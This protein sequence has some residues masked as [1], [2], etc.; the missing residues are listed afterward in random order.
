MLIKSG[1]IGLILFFSCVR[2]YAVGDDDKENLKDITLE[3]CDELL[4][5][6][7]RQRT[8]E[9]T[10]EIS[11]VREEITFKKPDLK[12]IIKDKRKTRKRVKRKDVA[13]GAESFAPDSKWQTCFTP[14]Q[15]CGDFLV[16]ILNNA[17]ESIHLQAYV[18]SSQV[19]ANALVD[20][21]NRGCEVKVLVDNLQLEVPYSKISFLASNGI[22]VYVDAHATLAHNKVIV[23]DKKTTI[24]GS[25]NLSDAA[26][27][28]NIENLIVIN[29]FKV[30]K[31]YLDNF[32]SRYENCLRYVN[33][34][35]SAPDLKESPTRKRSISRMMSDSDFYQVDAY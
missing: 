16:S 9:P 12:K 5:P 19:I 29:D 15:K 17:Q 35:P 13:S 23:V 4:H 14:Q 22:S 2:A 7:K 30:S 18:L 25:Y 24:T 31:S 6:K 3:N 32:I 33:K 1:I 10:E 8:I 34:N 20:A 11:L 27:K 28:R 21:H 26:E